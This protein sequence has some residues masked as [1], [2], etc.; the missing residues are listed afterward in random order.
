MAARAVAYGA[1][2]FNWAV[3]RGTLDVN[4]FARLPTTRENGP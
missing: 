3:A 1:S 2:C 4:P